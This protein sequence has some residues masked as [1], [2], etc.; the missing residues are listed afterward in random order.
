MLCFARLRKMCRIAWGC[1]ATTTGWRWFW[2]WYGCWKLFRALRFEFLVLRFARQCWL[3]QL[4]RI[5]QFGGSNEI[6]TEFNRMDA[7]HL[8]C[9]GVFLRHRHGLLCVTPSESQ[10]SNLA[11]QRGEYPFGGRR[12]YPGLSHEPVAG[13]A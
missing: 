10:R 7:G 8:K 6:A 3:V 11:D 4:P 2:I 13:L 12:D 1:C 5:K 9:A